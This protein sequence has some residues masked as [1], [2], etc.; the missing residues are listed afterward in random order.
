MFIVMLIIVA[1]VFIGM[2]RMAIVE[3]ITAFRVTTEKFIGNSNL[4]QTGVLL[5][6]MILEKCNLPI[7][8]LGRVPVCN[9]NEFSKKSWIFHSSAYLHSTRPR[10]QSPPARTE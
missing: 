5:I 1:T 7:L 2:F 6:G 10:L 4:I 8:W 9:N 3:V